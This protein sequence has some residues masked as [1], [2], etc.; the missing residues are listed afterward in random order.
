MGTKK[1]KYKTATLDIETDP[2][3]YG[4]VPLPFAI[5][6]YDGENYVDFWGDNCVFDMCEYLMTLTEPHEIFVHNGGGFDFWYLINWICNPVF[7]INRKI[8]YCGFGIHKLRDSYR[9]IPI[10]LAKFNKEE[11]DYAKFERHCRNKHKKEILH[12]LFLDCKYLHDMVTDFITRYGNFITIG[13]AALKHLKKFHPNKHEHQFFD[14]LFRPYYLGG[15]TQCFNTGY[16]KGPLRV[17]D[18]NSSYPN[19][20]RNYSHPQGAQYTLRINLPQ[21]GNTYFARI[22]AESKG[23]LPIKTKK[24]LEFPF[25]ER[26]FFACSHEIIAAQRLGLLKVK[27]VIECREWRETQRFDKYVDHFIAEKIKC[28]EMGDRGGREFA[29]LFLNSSYGKFG[30]NPER[31]SD[32]EL[33]DSIEDA[34]EKGFTTCATFGDRLIGQKP[35]ELKPW[36]FNNVAIAASITS[37]ARA[38]L[39]IAI[40]NAKRP[41]Y[42]DTDSIV[43]DS[44]NADFH[45]TKLGAWKDEGTLD[46]IYI[47]GKKLYAGFKDG[48]CVKKASKGV[49]LDGDTIKRICLSGETVDVPIAAPLLRPGRDAQFIARK[50]RQT[51]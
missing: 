31:Y 13:S 18:I 28:E 50:I 46:E 34:E 5:G 12:Y 8:A 20:M 47:A 38:E 6:F 29:K 10:P 25:G 17:Y 3:Q 32:C 2:F 49:I 16:I 22:I 41:I 1:V 24:G 21:N 40:T 4:R 15:R 27:K 48:Q 51:Y 36:S 30:Q 19:V 39:L 7:F 37:A 42:C 26:E 35:A 43:C 23:A 14:A 33:F 45:S 44:L 9:M 11:I